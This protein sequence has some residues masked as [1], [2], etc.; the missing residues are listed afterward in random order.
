MDADLVDGQHSAHYFALDDQGR[1]RLGVPRVDR[2]IYARENGW[3]MVALASLFEATGDE[4]YRKEAERAADWIGQNRS[5]AGGGFR[6][7]AQDAS[8]PYLADS[9]AM[10]QAFLKLYECTGERKWLGKASEDL[11]FIDAHFR[12]SGSAGFVTSAS[13]TGSVY[14]PRP[15]HDENIALARTAGL[16]SYYT[17]DPSFRQMAEVA[18]RYAVTPAIARQ[19]SRRPCYWW[20]AR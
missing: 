10:S 2:H 18:M 6:H 1:R 8:G 16:L 12:H 7:D 14:Q 19:Y 20:I 5:L 17:G 11:H 13:S 9:L 4:S 3:A 15:E